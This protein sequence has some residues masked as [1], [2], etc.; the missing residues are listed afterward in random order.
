MRQDEKY[1]EL[2]RAAIPGCDGTS[3]GCPE[4]E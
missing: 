1:R 2:A 4:R 3:K